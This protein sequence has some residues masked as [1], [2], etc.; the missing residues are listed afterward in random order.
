M[1]VKWD[2]IRNHVWHDSWRCEHPDRYPQTL[3]EGCPC[4]LIETLQK[5]GVPDEE[6]Q[7]DFIY[8]KVP[9][10]SLPEQKMGR[11]E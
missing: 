2:E 1:N 8:R 6:I 10:S 7:R 9:R 4:G 11:D 3:E 5:L